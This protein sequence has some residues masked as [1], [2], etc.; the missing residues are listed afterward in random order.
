MASG[1]NTAATHVKNRITPDT[2]P[3]SGLRKQLMP[4]ELS[5]GYSTDMKRPD[6][7]RRRIATRTPASIDIPKQRSMARLNM[8]TTVAQF[9][10]ARTQDPMNLPAAR[11]TKKI[12]IA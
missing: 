9:K 8:V 2:A 1:P 12:E 7:G 6:N 3:C 4:F 5:V 11:R 10:R